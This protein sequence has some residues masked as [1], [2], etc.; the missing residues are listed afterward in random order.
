MNKYKVTITETTEYTYELEEESEELAADQAMD[1]YSFGN[2][3]AYS[4]YEHK[5]RVSKIKNIG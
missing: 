1:D 5:P 2:I 3:E 4:V